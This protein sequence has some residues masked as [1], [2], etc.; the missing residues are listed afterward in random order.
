MIRT[1]AILMFSAGLSTAAFADERPLMCFGTEPFWSVD[2]TE[3]GSGLARFSTMDAESVFYQGA[4]NRKEHLGESLWRGA[5]D[6]GGDLVVWMQDSTCS[7]NMSDTAHPVTT[8]VSLPDGQFLAGCCRVVTQAAK[9]KQAAQVNSALEGPTWRLAQIGGKEPAGLAS[10]ERAVSVTFTD[11]RAR[12][13]SGC[14]NFGGDYQREGNRLQLGQLA[15]TM[16]ACPKPASAI[17]NSFQ[18][19]FGGSFEYS[20]DGD[21]LLLSAASGERLLFEREAPLQLDGSA[22]KVTSFNNNRQAVIG[23]IG[24]SDITLMFGAEEV[25][26][27]AGCNRFWASYTYAGN[28]ITFGPP[29]TTRM[30]CEESLMTQEQLFLAALASA[31]TWRIDGNV[32][33]MHR[34]DSERAIWAISQ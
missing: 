24:D 30:A 28:S 1:A 26:G 2:L 25:S 34:A 21:S 20:I 31:V 15:S 6:E 9:M 8:R 32:L 17:E 7:D 33:D 27:S 3:P 23:V 10:L 22:W 13:F 29:A 12:G 11:G 16:M 4:A 18:A 5:S 14:N 19:A